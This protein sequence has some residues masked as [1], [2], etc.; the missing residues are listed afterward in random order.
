MHDLLYAARSLAKSPALTAVAVLTLALGIGANATVFSILDPLLLRTL[1]VHEPGRLVFVGSAGLLR[2]DYDTA[3]LSEL[4]AYRRYRDENRVFSGMFAFAPA[5]QLS[6]ARG[7]E[8]IPATGEQVT[9]DYFAVLGVRPFAGRL[10]APADGAG[11]IAG[12]VAVLSYRFWRRAFH[13]NTAAIGQ[14][15]AVESAP[16]AYPPLPR[17]AYRVVGIAPPGFFG[18][19]V[20]RDPDLYLPIARQAASPDWITILGRL[21]PRITFAQARASLEPIFEVSVAHST[22]PAIEKRQ[23]MEHLVVESAARGLSPLRGRVALGIEIAMGVVALLL[24]IAC[25][26]VA[27]LLLARGAARARE[28]AIRA[29]L[30]AGAWQQVRHALAETSLLA[31]GGGAA[32]VLAAAWCGKLLA[33]ALST[34]Q[35]PVAL[36][37]RLDAQVFA[38]CAA[39][40]AG[41]VLLCA[42][43][44]ALSAARADPVRD[45]K[46]AGEAG[47]GPRSRWGRLLLD[48]QAATAV[49]V[50]IGAGLLLRSLAN[51]ESRPAGFD[52]NHVLAVRLAGK[53][54][55]PQFFDHLRQ[56]VA[57]LPGVHAASYSA[58]LPLGEH[59]LGINLKAGGSAGQP[60]ARAH[61]F[62]D[63]V[64]PGYLQA[65]GIPLL[66]GRGFVAADAAAQP[67]RVAIV[68]RALAEHY[69]PGR[70][71]VGDSFTLAE[72]GRQL[73]IVGVAA[74]SIYNDVREDGTDFF[75][76]P[77]PA[78]A[79]P[80]WLLVHAAGEPSSLAEPIR[81]AIRA[82][83]PNVSA[84]EAI[85]LRRQLDDSLRQDRLVAVLCG[86]F[87]LL[88][89]ALACAGIYGLLSFQ[90]ARRTKEFGI[91]I[92]LGARRRDIFG[93]VLGPVMGVLAAAAAVGI[94]VSIA[95]TRL[96]AHLL[97]GVRPVDLPTYAAVV[98]MIFAV[99]LAAGCA[100]ARR[101]LRSDPL[102]ALRA[103]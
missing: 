39:I 50:L 20:G 16:E 30:G 84:S 56:R 24:L 100:P 21:E 31:A 70:N 68:N 78:A 89:L 49:I 54:S 59:E 48:A 57:A 5:E 44:P 33:V 6:V 52:A 97:F 98:V 22:L 47:A 45:L 36:D 26:N 35:L 103:E 29:A 13:S 81:A 66:R 53:P 3:K 82:L 63:V 83:D 91:R 72:S 80:A 19:E 10:F 96:L 73:R 92:A 64:A 95:L 11:A 65:M 88:A 28:Q 101:A 75:Y 55:S 67:T 7:G 23:V 8:P 34:R 14:T 32:G 40:L 99:A 74:S 1:P 46:A 61:A 87:A 41:A 79:R 71:S 76:L 17:R 102:R 25:A 58:L 18:V 42:L 51:L 90:V 37:V 60:A 94:A 69:F 77:Y 4:A 43:A 27:N 12:P 85:T 62:F 93:A 86:V 15:I 2:P 9:T 38:F